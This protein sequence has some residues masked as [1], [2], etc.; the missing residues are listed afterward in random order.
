MR[1]LFPVPGDGP[2]PIDQYVPDFRVEVEGN[3]LDETTKGDVLDLRVTMDLDA[4]AS[5]ELT[6]NNWDDRQLAFKHS[7]TPVLDIGNRVHVL[8]GYAGGL[9]SMLRGQIS[10]MTPHFPASGSPTIALSVLDGMQILKENRPRDGETRQYVDKA[11]WQ[12]AQAVA[13]RNGLETELT[14][15]GPVHPLVVQ[16]DQDDASFL[17]ERAARID[18]ECYVFTDP[19]SG[20]A[21][22]RFAQP[23]DGRAAGRQRAHAFAWGEDLISFE[24]TLTLSGQ[25]GKVTVRGWN[26]QAKEA[27]TAVAT[28]ADIPGGDGTSGPSAAERLLGN[29][30]DVV[31]DAPVASEEEARALAISLLRERGYHFITANGQVIGK[32]ELRPGDTIDLTGLGSRFSGSYYVK[33]VEHSFG[34]QGYLTRFDVRRTHDAGP[35]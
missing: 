29:R 2:V 17:A 13:D 33:K 26:P 32:P 20:N 7:D 6:L 21:V 5:A 12:I 4:M 8:M 23:S 19:D 16:R 22:L 34:G 1:P 10:S 24:P 27:I 31:I 11:D 3:V 35:R 18:F 30:Q 14:R 9:V 15:E 25:V 28:P